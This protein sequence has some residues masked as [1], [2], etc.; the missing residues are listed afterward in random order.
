MSRIWVRMRVKIR[1]IMKKNKKKGA[2]SLKRNIS[3][4]LEEK[5]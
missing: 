5:T 3:Q 1:M 4:H 2:A